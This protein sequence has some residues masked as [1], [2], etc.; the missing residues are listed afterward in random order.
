MF[1]M[2]TA[3]SGPQSHYKT[4]C[5]GISYRNLQIN[6]GSKKHGGGDNLL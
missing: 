4:H 3:L 2:G 1:Y 6:G 5:K